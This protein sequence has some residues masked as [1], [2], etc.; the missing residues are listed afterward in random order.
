MRPDG[1]LL[2][3]PGYDE[4]IGFLRFDP[5][6]MP[7]IPEAPTRRDAH[8]ASKVLC[9]L[10]AEFP[11]ADE[12]SRSVALSMLM[13]P[14]LRPALSPAVPLHNTSAPSPGAGK[15]YLADL[16]AAIATG[17]RCPVITRSPSAEETEKRLVGAALTGQPIIA[18]DNVNGELRSDFLCQA[19]ERPLLQVRALG[20]SDLARIANAVTCSRTATTSSS[21][22]T[23]CAAQ[24]SAH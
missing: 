22:R 18:I 15:S 24:S 2:I 21:P 8:A 3:E 20:T 17:E 1:T 12:A 16:A 5:P 4:P 23:W 13:T 10:L 11:F 14:T 19:V 6:E 9:G 7:S